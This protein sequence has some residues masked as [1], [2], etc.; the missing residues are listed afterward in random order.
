ETEILIVDEVLAVGDVAFQ[1][2]CL[3]KMSEITRDGRTVLFVSHNI[4]SIQQLAGSCLL[5]DAGRLVATGA[6][7]DVV[8]AYLDSASNLS[9]DAG[10]VD[11]LPRRHLGL[12][13]S[14]R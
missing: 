11:L 2:K 9:A 10:S 5:I 3:A 6:T 8:R 1:Q 13:Q 14:I 12:G 4:S 7:D